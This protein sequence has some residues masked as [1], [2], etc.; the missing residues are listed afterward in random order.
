MKVSS[1]E[2]Q[3]KKNN[4]LMLVNFVHMPSIEK[5]EGKINVFNSIN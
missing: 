3:W 2:W 1:N 4:L 5:K